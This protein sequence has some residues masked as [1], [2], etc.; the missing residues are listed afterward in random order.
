MIWLLALL[1]VQSIQTDTK[2]SAAFISLIL[3]DNEMLLTEHGGAGLLGAHWCIYIGCL[4]WLINSC[5]LWVASSVIDDST[6][7]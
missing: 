7:K 5:C 2:P 1:F 3:L 4:S 6:Y